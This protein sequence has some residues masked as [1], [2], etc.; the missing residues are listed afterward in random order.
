M[1]VYLGQSR[2]PQSHVCFMSANK[3]IMMV[4]DDDD[5]NCPFSHFTS[6]LA[7]QIRGP[8]DEVEKWPVVNVWEMAGSAMIFMQ[9][10]TGL[11]TI[12]ISIIGLARS[13]FQPWANSD[14]FMPGRWCQ[15]MLWISSRV[16]WEEYL[17]GTLVALFKKG[18]VRIWAP[19][20][21]RAKLSLMHI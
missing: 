4:R 17:W 21:R 6:K 20:C 12:H 5:A 14:D 7:H 15:G 13:Q 8:R 3:G 1:R 2:N 10:V 11:L 9:M 19:F 16:W 18:F